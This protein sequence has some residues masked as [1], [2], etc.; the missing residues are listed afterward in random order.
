MYIHKK[1]NLVTLPVVLVE[2][3]FSIFFGTNTFLELFSTLATVCTCIVE[4]F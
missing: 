2:G 1:F 3:L 4:T